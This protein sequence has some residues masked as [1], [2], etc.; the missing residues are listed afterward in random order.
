MMFY[1]ETMA[2][3]SAEREMDGT[4]IEVDYRFRGPPHSGN[5]GY[6][7]GLLARHAG[8]ATAAEVTLR[9]PTPLGR[10]LSLIKTSDGD[11]TMMDGMTLIGSVRAFVADIDPLPHATLAEAK[12]ATDRSIGPDRH[13]LPECFVCGPG[14]AHGDGLRV[15][16]GPLDANDTK[17]EGPLAAD[18]TPDESFADDDGLV[19]TEFLWS[20]LDCPTGYTALKPDGHGGG[21][22]QSMLLGRIAVRIDR[23]PPVGEPC[24]LVTK[25]IGREGRK[26]TADG[27]LRNT[28]GETLAIARAL[29]ITV[30]K[31]LLLANRTA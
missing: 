6:V 11:T 27:M 23:R 29:W 21:S 13:V 2:E 24:V 25:L 18:W 22:N 7:S 4:P 8:M 15:F 30:D 20:A 26:I 1:K 17:W 19:A 3:F 16:A 31:D 10:P 14:R 12:A 9:A 5:G 28:A